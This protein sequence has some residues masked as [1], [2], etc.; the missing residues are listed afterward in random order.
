[1]PHGVAG[2]S[3]SKFKKSKSRA[4]HDGMWKVVTMMNMRDLS[5]D[6]DFL[7]HLL[8][9]KLG[10]GMVPLVVHKMDPTRRLPKTD[11]DQL[12]QIVRR[13]IAFRGPPKAALNRAV[14]ELLSLSAVRYYLS[15]YREMRQVN[16]FATHASRYFE[17]YLPSG[18]IEIAH[19]SRYSHRTGKSELCILATRPLAKDQVITELK[20]SMAD[21]SPE[22]DQELKQ[23]NET[24]ADGVSVRRDFSVIH[25]KQL[26]K[27]HLFLGPARF[28]N[29]DCNHNV[30]LFRTGRYITFRVR[31]PIAVG[32]EV[33]ANYG[34]G[35][36]GRNNRHCLCASC[37]AQGKGGYRPQTSSD[38][39]DL[40]DSGP[41]VDERGSISGRSSSSSDDSD[42]DDGES[43]NV[44]ERRTRRGV[45]AVL[46]EEQP[47]SPMVLDAD[48][49]VDEEPER[50]PG[51]T[52]QDASSPRRSTRIRKETGLLT[53]SSEPSSRGRT[54]GRS[55]TNES[56]TSSPK[57][58]TTVSESPAPFRSVISTRA[59]KAREASVEASVSTSRTRGKKSG[60]T[61]PARPVSTNRQLVTPPLT[62]NNSSSS[63][64]NSVRS[65]SRLRTR[66]DA[67][68]VERET[69]SSQ[70]ISSKDKGKGKA[71]ASSVSDTLDLVKDEPETR[72]LRPRAPVVTTVAEGELAKKMKEGPRGLDGKP[73]PT[74]ITCRNVLPVISVD[75]QV[76]WGLSVGRTGKRGRPRKNIEVDCPR[77]IRH[78]AIYNVKWPE[79]KPV[80]GTT[81]FDPPPAHRSGTFTPIELAVP[82]KLTNS[83]LAALERSMVPSISE[84]ISAGGALK[85]P[86][87]AEP[88][89]RPAKKQ[90]QPTGRPRGR[91]PKNKVGM[92][93]KAKAILGTVAPANDE[94]RSGRARIPSM[95]IRES[96]PPVSPVSP[97]LKSPVLRLRI[98][99]RKNPPT[100]TTSPLSAPPSSDRMPVDVT[101][102]LS[103][104]PMTPPPSGS[105]QEGVIKT[106]KSM[107]V[108]SQ[109]REANGRFG[110]KSNT[111]G[112][113]MRKQYMMG[114]R[115][116]RPGCRSV[117]LILNRHKPPGEGAEAD[118][119]RSDDEVDSDG[120]STLSHEDVEESLIFGSQPLHNMLGK[121]SRDDQDTH[122][123]D[124]HAFERRLLEAE[125]GRMASG[126]FHR[127][128]ADYDDAYDEDDED[129][130]DENDMEKVTYS[131]EHSPV[132]SRVGMS[133]LS[134]PNPMSF[135]RRKWAPADEDAA[136]DNDVDLSITREDDIELRAAG[137]LSADEDC[138][139]DIDDDGLFS[140]SSRLIPRGPYVGQM[141]LKPSPLNLAR[142]RWAPPPP[143]FK[144]TIGSRS[145]SK[146]FAT[147]VTRSPSPI[148]SSPDVPIE[149]AIEVDVERL[150]PP[151]KREDSPEVAFDPE[152]SD[153]IPW[154]QREA[155]EDEDSYEIDRDL[156]LEYPESEYLLDAGASPNFGVDSTDDSERIVE[157]LVAM[158]GSRTPSSLGDNHDSRAQSPHLQS[159]PSP[160]PD[161]SPGLAWKRT[162]L[163]PTDEPCSIPK[164]VKPPVAIPPFP[165]ASPTKLIYAGWDTS[166]S[167]LDPY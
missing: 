69:R 60:S 150:P 86:R 112:R 24:H 119:I 94:R 141:T 19:T 152:H 114:G 71:A 159:S 44:N 4:K 18:S 11:A 134:R 73:L 45:Y 47:D 93:A 42:M 25:S 37:E 34:D 2:S 129:E 142:R 163:L 160:S 41:E 113:Y 133:L 120:Q 20:G 124:E 128:D 1:M 126:R 97:V 151:Q 156:K 35:Y 155:S 6:D 98:S 91:P 140:L 99:P 28:V 135:A 50:T 54:R 153:D 5:R 78:F 65:S 31:R 89:T 10:T 145:T 17:L 38:E 116:A 106:P 22:E 8:V 82:N 68:V 85:R 79:R 75:S 110:K 96:E 130:P 14:E 48:A 143:K 21:L 108:A 101:F 167:D 29:H 51:S 83:A 157:R 39:E 166:S 26:K 149:T 100:P 61:A 40:T 63:A 66:R 76:V 139:E 117:R 53:P 70:S 67:S 27:N 33:T 137:A 32:E 81:A 87:E 165:P 138:D 162:V 136:S 164:V 13:L 118:R 3:S 103:G 59:Q 49:E 132:T 36:F 80:D 88:E 158:S 109:P 125:D 131:C 107:A 147:P 72:S 161:Y 111:N 92:S 55:V 43:V 95:K 154:W 104:R 62:A 144:Q 9:E 122:G 127:F 12:L 23:T 90:K 64:P 146:S 52:S 115:L 74:C 148:Q 123:R 105:S 84:S 56:L 77:C 121:R 58:K 16:A 46:P 15:Q 102:P 30:E 7:S 57:R